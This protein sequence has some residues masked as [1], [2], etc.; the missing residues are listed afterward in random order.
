MQTFAASSHSPAAHNS[1]ASRANTRDLGS[2]FSI[3]LYIWMLSA[4]SAISLSAKR[5]GV[6]RQPGQL[7][8][9]SCRKTF[10]FAFRSSQSTVR[11][12]NAY[13]PQVRRFA[14]GIGFPSGSPRYGRASAVQVSCNDQGN[15]RR[16]S[17]KKGY[18]TDGPERYRSALRRP[19][20][21]RRSRPVLPGAGAVCCGP[22]SVSLRRGRRTACSWRTPRWVY[23]GR[24]RDG[25]Q[26][27]SF[28]G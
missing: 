22:F 19:W 27:P 28:V 1:S 16:A 26:I 9:Q 13:G 20:S 2:S 12:I 11:K 14:S 25:R 10:I 8:S 6:L 23:P 3:S 4:E 24:A 15:G 7:W 18:R 17:L 21:K 5:P